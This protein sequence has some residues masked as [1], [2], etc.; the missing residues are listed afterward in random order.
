MTILQHP[1]VSACGCRQQWRCGRGCSERAWAS[2]KLC[3]LNVVKLLLQDKNNKMFSTKIIKVCCSLFIIYW[4]QAAAAADCCYIQPSAYIVST[5][6][7]ILRIW[8]YF[9]N[10]IPFHC[11]YSIYCD[12]R[13]CW[14]NERLFCSV[15]SCQCSAGVKQWWR[16]MGTKINWAYFTKLMFLKIICFGLLGWLRWII[17]LFCRNNFHLREE[18]SYS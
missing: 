12:C 7:H 6:H 9:I 1:W 2:Q 5:S 16:E 15:A 11:T 18:T 8:K 13:M 14:W 10:V 17:N 3:T 4:K